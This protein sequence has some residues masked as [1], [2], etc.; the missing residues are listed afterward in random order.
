M[1]SKNLL[2][3]V[4]SI[5]GAIFFFFVTIKGLV[6]LSGS[7]KPQIMGDAYTRVETDHKVVALTFDDGPNPPC[8]DSILEVL[9]VYDVK[10]T[11]FVVGKYVEKYP[12][13]LQQIVREGHE[14]GNH[15][16]SHKDLIFKSP[17]FIIKDILKTDSIIT[18][19]GYTRPIT[20]R[21]PRGRKLL[22]LPYILSRLQKC[23]I[24][25]DIVPIDWE[26]RS[27]ESM[28]KNILHN[29]RPGSIIL[30]HDGDGDVEHSNRDATVQL[31]KMAIEVLKTR[32]YQ[33]VTI[34]E[35]LE[36]SLTN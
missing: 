1:N 22:F 4:P 13:I 8:T 17:K 27:V 33:F 24:L 2:F 16:W 25:F 36:T 28:L 11:F 6:W 9:R 35:L 21:A 19:L 32:G 12:G 26:N 15:S 14:V 23:H 10:A 34:S 29:V 30:L 3:A 18:H 7:D 20:F 5:T 31:T